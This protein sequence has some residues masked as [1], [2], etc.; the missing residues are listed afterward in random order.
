MTRTVAAVSVSLIG[1]WTGAALLPDAP[2]F[3]RSLA[4]IAVGAATVVMCAL[5]DGKP[6]WPSRWE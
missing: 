1:N 2:F 4:L 3:P 6:I 5:L